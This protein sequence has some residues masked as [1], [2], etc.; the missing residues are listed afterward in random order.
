VAFHDYADYFP[1]VRAFVDHLI[2]SRRY[3]ALGLARSMIVL[4]RAAAAGD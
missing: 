2:E 1:G 4:R 3:D